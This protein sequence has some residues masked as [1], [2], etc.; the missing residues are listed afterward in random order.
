ME[1]A[2]EH[3]A[4]HSLALARLNCVMCCCSETLSV[5]SLISNPANNSLSC[6]FTKV[7]MDVEV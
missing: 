5:K 2:L 7:K 6:V 3:I 1:I 4:L